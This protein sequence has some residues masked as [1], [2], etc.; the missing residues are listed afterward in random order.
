MDHPPEPLM[1]LMIPARP[2][3]RPREVIADDAMLAD[4]EAQV[5]LARAGREAAMVVMAELAAPAPANA[6]LVAPVPG[7]VAD[8]APGDAWL[9][10]GCIG[11]GTGLSVGDPVLCRAG[12]AHGMVTVASIRLPEP[13]GVRHWLRPE[14]RCGQEAGHPGKHWATG[15]DGKMASVGWSDERPAGEAAPEGPALCQATADEGA[16]VCTLPAGHDGPHDD[17]REE[18]DPGYLEDAAARDEDPAGDPFMGRGSIVREVESR[19]LA[20]SGDPRGDSGELPPVPLS[21]GHPR[22]AALARTGASS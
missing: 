12:M 14:L 19:L 2:G 10:C 17:D 20:A 16:T 13:C 3:A 18:A 9:S 4:I 22:L 11:S 5:K 1:R 21:T 8:L 15:A 7:A 6:P